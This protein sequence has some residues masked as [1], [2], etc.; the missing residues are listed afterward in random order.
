MRIRL[1]TWMIAVAL[2]TV[3]LVSYMNAVENA[4]VWDDEDQVVNNTFIRDW[5]N[6]FLAF[7]SSTFHSGGSRLEGVFYRP[8]VTIFYMLNHSLW[9]LNPAGFHAVQ[10]LIHLA[11][12]LLVFFLLQLMLADHGIPNSTMI[13][14][15][16]SLMFAVHPVNVEATAYIGSMGEV[17]Y[18]FFVLGGTFVFL[19]GVDSGRQTVRNANIVGG[20]CL[21]F[22][23]LL[24]KE[25][26]VIAIPL[27]V[28]YTLLLLKLN[29]STYLKLL[30]GGGA[31]LGSYTFLRVSIAGL[32][33][34]PSSHAPIYEA[35]LASRFLTIPYELF[36][37]MKI[38]FFPA[39]LSIARHFVVNSPIDARFW[40]AL[41]ALLM[42]TSLCAI[43]TWRLKSRLFGF[44]GLW[45]L[46][47]LAPVLN[48][49]PLEMTIAERWMY[50]P[51]VGITT[52]TSMVLVPVVD[53]LRG[54]IRWIALIAIAASISLLSVRTIRRNQDWKDGMSLYAHDIAIAPRVSPGG[55]YELENYYG[56][57]LFGVDRIDE[58]AQHFRRSIQIQPG[59]MYSHNNLGA[60]LERQGDVEGALNEYKTSIALG[61]YYLAYENVAALLWHQKRYEEMKEFVMT[62]IRKFPRNSK[63]K[64]DLAVLYAENPFREADA[65]RKALMWTSLALHDDPQNRQ[66]KRLS[67]L[68]RGVK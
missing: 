52:M 23:G 17:L 4:F 53:S 31:V 45:F 38:I 7:K 56:M 43:Y 68:L 24:A 14:A 32:P 3:S 41:A 57:A 51:L 40:A 44:F 35:S 33:F 64:L 22:L 30:I 8:L 59:W 62:A 21:I 12:V 15:L 37:Y 49:L 55:S 54:Q 42:I 9:G 28:L 6:V 5:S 58:A 19:S 63:L 46:M 25:S 34:V 1:K 50:V 36:S 26:A 11:N 61:D 18:A 66:A 10:I 65:A 2:L 67:D 27:L 13:A 29:R 48:L 20:L 16:S 47:A 60:V 39:D